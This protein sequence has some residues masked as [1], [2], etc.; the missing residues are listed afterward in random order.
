MC[1]LV[2]SALWTQLHQGQVTCSQERVCCVYAS[3]AYH[4]SFRQNHLRTISSHIFQENFKSN[5]YNAG[6]R[7]TN[8][9]LL[10]PVHGSIKLKNNQRE[11]PIIKDNVEFFFRI[12]Q[13]TLQRLE[14]ILSMEGII[15]SQCKKGHKTV[16]N[17]LIIIPVIKKNDV[18]VNPCIIINRLLRRL[19]WAKINGSG[20]ARYSVH[21]I[22]MNHTTGRK[23]VES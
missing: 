12:Y 2:I 9:F 10:M 21:S 15:M 13:V 5:F 22:T 6:H 23:V 18:F 14:S 8:T 20:N 17:I 19:P 1:L 11:F 3:L 7:R 16:K 4:P